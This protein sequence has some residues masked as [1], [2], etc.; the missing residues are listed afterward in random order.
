VSCVLKK[1][2]SWDRGEKKRSGIA[3][4]R[5][6][7][8]GFGSSETPVKENAFCLERKKGLKRNQAKRKGD[9]FVAVARKVIDDEKRFLR[10]GK[11]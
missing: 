6:T 8:S 3:D 1:G 10:G 7:K 2:L 4:P 11:N 9:R 5:S